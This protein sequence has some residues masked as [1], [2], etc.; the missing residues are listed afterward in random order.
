MRL[1]VLDSQ[2]RAGLPQRLADVSRPDPTAAYAALHRLVGAAGIYGH[3]G[4]ASQARQAMDALT[5][6][7]AALHTAA[8]Q[9]LQAEIHKLLT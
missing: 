3:T 7:D 9:R 1:K 8:L 6:G 2:F 5:G 4:L